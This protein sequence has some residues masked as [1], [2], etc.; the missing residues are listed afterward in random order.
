MKLYELEFYREHFFPPPSPPPYVDPLVMEAAVEEVGL[1]FPIEPDFWY[2][3]KTWTTN[4]NGAQV[5]AWPNSGTDQSVPEAAIVDD[6]GENFPKSATLQRG[7]YI[8]GV[9]G[10][11]ARTR[12]G[13]EDNSDYPNFRW[14]FGTGS[15]LSDDHG[16][17]V[18]AIHG[19]E[20]T[21]MNFAG[22]QLESYDGELTICGVT[23][24]AGVNEHYQKLILAGDPPAAGETEASY[25]QG[26]YHRVAEQG[27]QLNDAA[28]KRA[29]PEVGTT[30]WG[31]DPDDWKVPPSTVDTDLFAHRWTATGNMDGVGFS[32]RLGA[33]DA[34]YQTTHDRSVDSENAFDNDMIRM[35]IDA[36][37]AH[38]R[39]P[40]HTH[41][42]EDIDPNH[43]VYPVNGDTNAAK[44]PKE[45]LGEWVV[46]CVSS[47]SDYAFINGVDHGIPRR[48]RTGKKWSKVHINDWGA[49]FAAVCG[50]PRPATGGRG[51][52]S[53]DR[54]PTAI[55]SRPAPSARCPTTSA[56]GSTRA[57][58]S[59]RSPSGSAG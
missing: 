37:K 16:S 19:Q 4:Y 26:H 53:A 39:A 13:L 29:W 6:S 32:T 27:G 44:E 23:A 17:A 51:R 22:T 50:R 12:A 36:S 30:R 24:Y 48:A 10:T 15:V 34:G 18:E 5:T 1:A 25:Y 42:S 43:R 57:S 7:R 46:S 31:P 2:K 20:S 58:S 21:K 55:G 40:R 56:T 33:Y 11:H 49:S 28:D 52:A 47:A 38:L 14:R 54:P 8:D 59:P 41:L 3:H 35:G 45:L 9:D